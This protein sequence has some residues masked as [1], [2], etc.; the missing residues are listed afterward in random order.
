VTTGPASITGAGGPAGE[1][2][3]AVWPALLAGCVITA[4]TVAAYAG[5]FSVPF[6]FDD[7]PSISEN[8][9]I[10]H[11]AAALRPP[12]QSTVGGRPVLNLTLAADYAAGGSAVWIYHA[13]NL[14]IH[15]LAALTLFAIVR[16]T[17]RALAIGC[18]TPAAFSAALLWA[19]HPLQTES[20]TYVIQRAESLMG[21][22]YLLT[23]YCFV[24]SVG[25]RGPGARLWQA[26]CALACL[27]GMATK[28]VMVSAPLVVL[29]YDATFAAG[30]V[31]AALR[32]RAPLYCLLAATWGVLALLVLSTHGRGGTAGFATGVAWWRYALAQGPAIAHYLRLCV[33]PHPLVF[34]YGRTLAPASPG[35]LPG[36]L[37][38]AGLLVATA[39][40]LLRRPALG[41]LGACF[42]LV[43]APSS[44]FVPVA[45]ETMAEH[46]MY[47]ALAPVVIVAVAAAWR[48]LGRFALAACLALA[49][50]LLAVT[51]QR[52]EAY[53]SAESLWRDVV[54]RR[55][56]NDRAQFDLGCALVAVPGRLDEAVVHFRE[57]LSLN[58]DYIE[59]HYNLGKAL[60]ALGRKTEAIAQYE[61]ALRLNYTQVDAHFCLGR[62]LEGI[63][64]GLDRAVA[65]Y[66]AAV[67]L[68]PDFAEAH[69]S[70]GVALEKV[71]GR[72][73]E[74]ISQYEEALRL[75][76]GL[77][78]ARLDLAGAL[79][80]VPGR[81][82]DSIAQYEEALR[83]RP[84]SA[85]AH[86]RF[87]TALNA[88]AGRLNEAVA[89]YG[90]ALRLKPDFADAHYGMGSALVAIPGRLDD[91]LAQFQEAL[92]LRPDYAEARCGLGLALSKTP[93]RLEE[94]VAQYEEAL[95]L[96]PDF[97][98]AHCNLAN[99][100][101]A[102]GRMDEA[103]A[104]FYEAL[105]IRPGDAIAHIDLAIALLKI[106]GRTAE[107]VAHLN[108]ALRLEP[109]NGAARQILAGVRDPGN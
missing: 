60:D 66:E 100:L 49:A 52:N 103:V 67:R 32:G 77:F 108:E 37:A 57:A 38:V 31:R 53:S 23:L 73:G 40:A 59:A 43:L 99:A 86:F 74:A 76:P 61:E 47:L 80:A 42:F 106:R 68:Q 24:R 10:R 95:R 89:Q 34:D 64:G 71:P 92:R 50:V 48:W 20:V 44:S 70:L 97:A 8:P 65:E 102:L 25:A 93:G 88:A 26:A 7:V 87:G 39:W 69:L 51:W 9:T 36:I 91:A 30:S 84:D 22:L 16:R 13:T 5:T 96:K 2:R 29:L 54:A 78:V 109:G 82:G 41:F 27:A 18:A 35:D 21:L 6:L 62:D 83:L 28:E 81:L 90:E 72:S 58:P 98:Q 101:S 85:E 3:P 46:R 33:W 56:A 15:V 4:A 55:P 94:A 1:P 12:E 45:T 105:Q 107:A 75:D 79:Q 17:L 104:Q 63:P 14:A 11:L 19:L